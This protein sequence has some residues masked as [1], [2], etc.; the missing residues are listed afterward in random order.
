MQL[1]RSKIVP[2][3]Q[4]AFWAPLPQ[5]WQ[6]L[7]PAKLLAI[8]QPFERESSEETT[9]VRLLQ[10]CGMTPGTNAHILVPDTDEPLSWWQVKAHFAPSYVLM[11]GILPAQLGISALFALNAANSFDGC[12]FI[13]T[14]A[15]ALFAQDT[16]T[17]KVVWEN[18]LKPLFLRP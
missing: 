10:A 12:A 7:P 11:F 6:Q 3:A 5:H 1:L 16:G 18:A 14:I 4:D 17:K 8:T 13:P 9:L 2:P 15:P